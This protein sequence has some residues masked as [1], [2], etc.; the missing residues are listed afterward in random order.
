MVGSNNNLGR[1]PEQ[2]AE[3]RERNAA[4]LAWLKETFEVAKRE[5]SKA[6]GIFRQANPRFEHGFPA[7]RRGSLGL[8]SPPKA[9]SGYGDFVSALEAEVV[10]FG[11]PVILLHGDTH[12]FR[13]D[14]PLF[15]TGEASQGDRGRQVENSRGWKSTVSPKPTGSG[16]SWIRPT[17]PCSVSRKRSSSGIAL[18]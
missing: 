9:P 11:K 10:S 8:A 3:Y 17:R 16:S 1:T 4:S 18:T 2:D 6:V 15:R 13:V 5:G 7:G 12:Y 14:K